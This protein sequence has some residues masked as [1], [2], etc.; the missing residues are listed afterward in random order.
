ML[1]VTAQAG[2][3]TAFGVRCVKE[4]EK[5]GQRWGKAIKEELVSFVTALHEHHLSTWCIT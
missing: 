4:P 1:D 5:E 2:D 3:A